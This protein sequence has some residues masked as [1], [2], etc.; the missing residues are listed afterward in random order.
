MQLSARLL[1]VYLLPSASLLKS[2]SPPSL[3]VDPPPFADEF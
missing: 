3:E 1:L 2:P